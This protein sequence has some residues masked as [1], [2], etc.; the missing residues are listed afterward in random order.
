MNE[1]DLEY[2]SHV[3]VTNIKRSKFNKVRISIGEKVRGLRAIPRPSVNG[4][5]WVEHFKLT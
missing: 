2:E 3:L 1:Y 4:Q 5:S